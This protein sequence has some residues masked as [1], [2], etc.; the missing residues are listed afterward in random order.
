M[1]SDNCCFKQAS[2][3]GFAK[4]FSNSIIFVCI[5]ELE[6]F[7]KELSL[8]QL[9]GSHLQSHILGGRDL[10]DCGL[11]PAL[12]KKLTWPHLNKQAEHGD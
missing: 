10:E 5:F 6:F 3:C 8:G 11:K 1:C 7:Y 9:R 2:C 4:W 12:A